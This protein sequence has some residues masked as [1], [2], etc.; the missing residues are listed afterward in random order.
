MRG[1]VCFCLHNSEFVG[2]LSSLPARNVQRRLL[3]QHMCGGLCVSCLR[4]PESV[5][6]HRYIG[7]ELKNLWDWN[8]CACHMLHLAVSL[9]LNGAT[10]NIRLQPLHKLCRHLS[11]SSVEWKK[12]KKRQQKVVGA[13]G[14]ESEGEGEVEYEGSASV[15]DRDALNLRAAVKTW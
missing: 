12:F 6:V 13:V 9:G 3:Q 5:G 8:K 11:R 1:A 2:V 10:I 4:N 7:V 14:S 15:I